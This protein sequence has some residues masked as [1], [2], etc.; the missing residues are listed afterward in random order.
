[1]QHYYLKSTQNL[2]ISTS[3]SFLLIIACKNTMHN[4]V[5]Q[6]LSMCS[7][8]ALYIVVHL[9]SAI[10]CDITNKAITGLLWNNNVHTL[11]KEGLMSVWQAGRQAVRLADD[12]WV[13]Y[14]ML[15]FRMDWNIWFFV[16]LTKINVAI[17]S[18]NTIIRWFLTIK[19]IDNKMV[20]EVQAIVFLI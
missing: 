15:K 11:W 17:Y 20:L 18:L 13:N 12:V 6:P 9:Q 2:C 7:I 16:T 8:N 4:L 10:I 14:K 5:N 3:W 19:P 1:M